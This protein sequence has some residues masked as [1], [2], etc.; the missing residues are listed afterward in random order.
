MSFGN[1]E[2]HPGQA[3]TEFLRNKTILVTGYSGF[4]GHWLCESLLSTGC[5]LIGA[6]KSVNAKI[7]GVE[8]VICDLTQIES[9]FSLFDK[10]RPDLVV[11]LAAQSQTTTGMAELANTFEVNTR[12]TWNIL[13]ALL[14]FS[15]DAGFIFASSDALY[16]DIGEEIATESHP[17]KISTPYASSKACSEL[18]VKSYA[19]QKNLKT[20]II[21]LGNLY[22]P[23]DSN[24]KRIVPGT[25]LSLLN[26]TR[27]EIRGDG[28]SIRSYLYI[29][30]AVDGFIK[31][32]DALFK[33]K[34]VGETFNLCD[35]S[36]VSVKGIV[37][38]IVD[39]MN[40][41][42]LSASLGNQKTGEI[43]IKQVSSKKLRQATGWQTKVT[44][45]QG[46]EQTIRWY[47][48]FNK[49]DLSGEQI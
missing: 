22:G 36:S 3:K 45:Q 41:P 38:T 35:E 1:L 44:L 29:L 32:I 21:R 14:Q 18:V 49:S 24:V 25:I 7:S 43:K 2:M 39:I 5:R 26:N 16:G 12:G 42:E 6:S 40:L 27:P 20:I 4:L 23:A 46:L 31:L 48:E 30:D 8:H 28:A 11:H 15:P 47:I 37:D 9:L 17:Y 10:Y 34:L 13:E 19:Q 33:N